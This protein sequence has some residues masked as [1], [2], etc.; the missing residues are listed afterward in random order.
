MH[1][2]LHIKVMRPIAYAGLNHW[3]AVQRERPDH[4]DYQ[5]GLGRERVQV[6]GRMLDDFDA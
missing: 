5:L 6:V 3:F 4:V 2:N 1:R